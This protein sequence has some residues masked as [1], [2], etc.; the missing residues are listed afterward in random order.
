MDDIK[1]NEKMERP[2][3]TGVTYDTNQVKITIFGLTR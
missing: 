3:V 2:V 1:N